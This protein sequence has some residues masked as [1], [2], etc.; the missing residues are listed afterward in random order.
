MKGKTS[1]HFNAE[2]TKSEI[3]FKKNFLRISSVSTEQLHIGTTNMAQKK[4]KKQ[5]ILQLMKKM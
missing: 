1:I 4:M 5:G 3:L 2:M